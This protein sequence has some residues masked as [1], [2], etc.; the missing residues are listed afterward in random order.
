MTGGGLI[1]FNYLYAFNDGE[2]HAY[3]EQ[4]G[5]PNQGDRVYFHGTAYNG[6]TPYNWHWDFGDG[7]ESTSQNPI[8]E[9]SS[10]GTYDVILTV[11]DDGGNIATASKQIKVNSWPG[12]AS[13]PSGPTMGKPG[14]EYT[15]S[16]SATDPDGDKL[17]YVWYWG[18]GTGPEAFGPYESGETCYAKHTWAEK[19]IYNI[20]V[21]AKDTYRAMGDWSDPLRVTMPRGRL[22]PNTF[23]LRLLERFPNAFPIL[24]YI[25]KL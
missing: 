14:V 22:L 6:V 9:Y 25:L 24:R 10:G 4:V 23:F 16:T 3:I 18:D 17:E 21:A 19:G 11:T 12:K 13:R 1:P 7:S 2:F 15:Y 20:E 5:M 8:Y